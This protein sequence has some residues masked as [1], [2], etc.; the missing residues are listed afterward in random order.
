MPAPKG[1]SN[2]ARYNKKDI[3]EA[4]QPIWTVDIVSVGFIIG[5]FMSCAQMFL[6]FQGDI[7][8]LSYIYQSILL[9]GGLGIGMV[10]VI[11]PFGG[12]GVRGGFPR[13]ET[14]PRFMMYTIILFLG[15]T[16]MNGVIG[17]I[18]PG[19][20]VINQG[21]LSATA[22][23][24]LTVF[25]SAVVEEVLF[26]LALGVILFRVMNAIATNLGGLG[27]VQ[28]YIALFIASVMNGFLFWAVHYGVYGT[29]PTMMTM[30]FANRVLYAFVFY[31]TR[32]LK[33]PMTLHVLH[34]LVAVMMM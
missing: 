19:S 30:L 3:Y 11:S 8:T 20:S 22:G 2:W 12:A 31:Y 32:D 7:A 18:V 13:P 34:N 26:T 5:A 17:A 4:N 27:I 1:Y 29:D 14:L 24:V 25:I 21:V 10:G 23:D 9:I 16:M 6:S 33:Y 15:S 28:Q